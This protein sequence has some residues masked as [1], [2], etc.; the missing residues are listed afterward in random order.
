MGQRRI[1]RVFLRIEVV[2][3]SLKSPFLSLCLIYIFRSA[4]DIGLA[5]AGSA[6]PIPPALN[7]TIQGRT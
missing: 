1:S 6:G 5:V 3:D 7:N 4:A 2:D